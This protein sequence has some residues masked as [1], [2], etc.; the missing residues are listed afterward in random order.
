MNRFIPGFIAIIHPFH[1]PVFVILASI[2]QVNSTSYSYE[3]ILLSCEAFMQK[4][5]CPHSDPRPLTH[6]DSTVLVKLPDRYFSLYSC[7]CNFKQ[8]AQEA[9]VSGKGRIRQCPFQCLEH[10]F[11]C[12]TEKIS[13]LIRKKT[14]CRPH[15]ATSHIIGDIR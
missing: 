15:N 12:R 3:A 4:L 7:M 11:F 1:D 8:F 10:L 13:R 2:Q 14:G 9:F 6:C 5:P